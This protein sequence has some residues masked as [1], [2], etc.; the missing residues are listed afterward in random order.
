M[1]FIILLIL[2]LLILL[3]SYFELLSQWNI[4]SSRISMILIIISLIGLSL[5]PATIVADEEYEWTIKPQ[6]AETTGWGQLSGTWNPEKT[7]L[8]IPVVMNSNG[9]YRLN[10]TRIPFNVIPYVPEGSKL[11]DYQ[12]IIFTIEGYDQLVDDYSLLKRTRGVYWANI[13]APDG[14]QTGDAY[15]CIYEFEARESGTFYFD[16]KLNYG[17]GELDNI[18]EFVTITITATDYEDLN[19]EYE[20]KFICIG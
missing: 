11:G 4:I 8:T 14:S 16:F 10:N 2:G 18:A 7:L 20:I 6:S 3:L 19:R 1:I 9:N 13:T 5:A 17:S 15:Q 12:T